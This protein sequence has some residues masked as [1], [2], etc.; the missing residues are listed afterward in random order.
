MAGQYV[1][2]DFHRRRSVIVRVSATGERLATKRVANDPL[3]IAA[4]V[5]EAGPDP[6]VVIEAT[7][8]CYWAVDVLQGAKVHLARLASRPAPPD[9]MTSNASYRVCG[10]ARPS[11]V[12]MGC[13]GL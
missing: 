7:Y 8:G 9:R 12:H 2:I 5:A 1:G 13:S 4:V 6:E 10:I 11:P 3:A